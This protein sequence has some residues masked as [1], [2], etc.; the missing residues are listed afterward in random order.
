MNLGNLVNPTSGTVSSAGTLWASNTLD[1]VDIVTFIFF[2]T[3]QVIS[4]L[5]LLICIIYIVKSKLDQR[6]V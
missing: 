3:L 1:A 6:N 4:I 2:R 5:A